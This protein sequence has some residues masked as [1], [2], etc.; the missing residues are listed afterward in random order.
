MLS[1]IVAGAVDKKEEEYR[2]S[3][4]E[5]LAQQKAVGKTV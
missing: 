4:T 1:Q 5:A 2:L 3:K